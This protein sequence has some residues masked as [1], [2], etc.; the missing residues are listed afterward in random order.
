MNKSILKYFIF[1][2]SSIFLIALDQLTK[3]FATKYLQHNK[4]FVIIDNVLELTYV[5]NRGAAFGILQNKQLLFYALTIVVLVAI[6]VLL[7]KIDDFKNNIFY[8]VFLILIFSGAIGNFIDRLKNKYVVD[9]I[10]FKPIDFPVFN[11]AD[12][13]I[14]IACIFMVIYLFIFDREK[15]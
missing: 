12:I 4:P 10:Y 1:V 6:C 2:V 8:F 5:E 7:Y 9:F 14:T 11:L 3:Y 15:K 13:Y